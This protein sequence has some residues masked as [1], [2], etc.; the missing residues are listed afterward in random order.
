M[1]TDISIGNEIKDSYKETHKWVQNNIKW[2]SELESFYRD[3]AKL[4]KEYSDK[5]VSYTHLDV[6]K[7]QG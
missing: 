1:S 4:E 7:R 3:R 2:L 5:S 6:Y